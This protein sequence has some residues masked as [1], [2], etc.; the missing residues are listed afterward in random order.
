VDV[1]ATAAAIE[2]LQA[3]GNAV[4]A[5]IA[6]SAVIG[7]TDPFS[8]GIGGGGFMVVYRAGARQ[9]ITVDSRE[10]AP[11]AHSGARFYENGA[12]IPF[13]ELMTSG[14]STGVP[15]TV[16]G[17]DEAQRR[18]GKL[19]FQQ[20]LQPAIR[21]ARHG[22][23]VDPTFVEQTRRNAERFGA[24][25]ST[26]RLFLT[27]E[28]QPH[29]VGST[30]RNPELA[31]T[32]E[33]LAAHG[34]PAFYRGDI[35]EAIVRTVTQPPVA[36]GA[37]LRVRP[38]VMTREDLANYEARIRA[39]VT[40]SWRGY[41]L[42]GMGPPTSGGLMVSLA[43]HLLEDAPAA[44]RSRTEHLHRYIEA[45]RLAF[46]DRNAYVADPEF[47][48]V[49]VEGLLSPA[50]AAERRQRISPTRAASGAVAPGNPFRFQRDP[51]SAKQFLP[52]EPGT[53]SVPEPG[54]M[55]PE[56]THITTSDAEGNIVAYTCTIEAEG[57]NGV[58]VPGYGFLLNNELTDFNVP[59]TP[60]EGHPNV[61]EPGKRP[62]SSIAPMLVF[63]DGQPVL[64]LGSPGGA[65]IIT[66]VLQ[67]LLNHFELGLPIDEALAAPR[68]SQL[69]P[70]T[71]ASLAEPEFLASPE[72]T[73]LQGLGHTFTPT[74]EIGALTAIRFH[75][76]GTVT[77]AAEP[78]RRGGGSAQVVSPAR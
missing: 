34:A 62:R 37:T 18:Y 40:T 58:V 13:P 75:A 64:A 56:T 78:R 48:S 23:T 33:L 6:A 74:P 51:S 50:Y 35:A 19:G 43:L 77:A 12:P 53:L 21:V 57:G 61:A 76:D 71:G 45:S 24:L 67:T 49:P 73:A 38:G 26:R 8:C 31:H 1:R 63:K 17:W 72:A 25:S 10:T 4:D 9:V 28:G 41:T 29:P 32:Y 42:Y 27:P 46:A 2:V 14:L 11:R 20:V 54:A 7:V 44:S 36:P 16:L 52:Q 66:T 68:V 47:V 15:G 22:F 30:F 39:P 3:G 5:A 60:G 70:P 69:N 65:T 59:A 55:D